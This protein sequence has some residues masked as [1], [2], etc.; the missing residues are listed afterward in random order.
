MTTADAPPPAT[1]PR[2]PATAWTLENAV[3][4]AAM[5]AQRLPWV[6]APARAL[7][8]DLL[9]RDGV[10]RA[11][12]GFLRR[13]RSGRPVQLRTPFGPFLL[14]LAAADAAGLLAAADEAGALAPAVG[15]TAGGRRY[16]LS[17]HVPLP[18][19]A[20]VPAAELGALLAEDVGRVIA[21]RRGDGTLDRADWERGMLRLSRRVVAGAAAAQDTLL[22]EVLAAAT[23]AA[24]TRS[25]E[26]R[27]E[28][29]RRRLAPHL[30]DPDPASLTGRLL[31]RGTGRE[32]ADPDAAA[33]AVAHALALVSQACADTALQALG[34]LAVGAAASPEAAVAEALRRWPP[35]AAAVY[36][37]RSDFVWQDLAVEAGTEILRVPGWLRGLDG[38]GLPDPAPAGSSAAEGACGMPP[39]CG[40]PTGCAATRFAALVAGH[41]VS[42]LTEAVRPLLIAPRFTADRL[43]DTLDPRTL[44]VALEDLAAP[45]DDGRVGVTL[46]TAVPVA[47]FGYAPA[48]YGA[49][50]HASADRLERHAQSLAACAGN[51]GWNADE[52]GE[53]YRTALLDHAERCATAAD[54]VRRA[55]K[56]LTD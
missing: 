42:A 8:L 40:A 34:L 24:G 50:A 28:A 11:L 51:S 48:A 47:A 4:S 21:A 7:G 27:A 18:C 53:R 16:G 54:G 17:P 3:F 6:D 37:V 46:P 56:R 43:P 2:R 55:A 38:E 35:V 30:A 19:D 20:A 25:Y 15:L 29:L 41:V 5:T 26:G 32:A 33:P 49:L 12:L 10:T 22:S 39:L 52:E 31:Q 13:T 1:A 14:P 45:P 36:P 9:T 23:A 44:V